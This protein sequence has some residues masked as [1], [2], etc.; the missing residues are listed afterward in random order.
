MEM[1]ELQRAIEALTHD[2]TIIM[3][4]HRLKT[5]RNADQILVLDGGK[6]V[7]HLRRLCRRQARER[8][9]EA[10]TP[11]KHKEKAP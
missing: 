4:A 3:I 9:L 11:A 10:L 6:I 2:K 5:V 8:R 1:D 7:Q